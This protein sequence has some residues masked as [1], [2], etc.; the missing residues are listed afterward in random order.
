MRKIGSICLHIIYAIVIFLLSNCISL[1]KIWSMGG[2][3]CI[4]TLLF[5]L[6]NIIPSFF[7]LSLKTTRLQIL[8]GG[9]QLL[10]LFLFSTV[11]SILYSLVGWCGKLS[12]IGIPLDS[13]I[14]KPLLW[15]FN[16]LFI[17]LIEL[18]VFWNGMIRIFL[19]S[20]QLGIRWRV[21]GAI[22]GFIPVAQLIVLGIMISVAENEVKVENNK[23]LLN[24][25]RKENRICNTKYPLLLV[26][27][28]FFRDSKYMNY[29]GRI[30]K[31]LEQN[32]ASIFYGNHHSAASVEACGQE[33]YERIMEIVKETGC[34][35]F[36]IIAHSKGGLDCRYAISACGADKYVA[37]LTTI[38]TPHRGCE[39][40]DYLLSKIGKKQQEAIAKAYNTTLRKFG[41]TNPDFLTAVRDL[42]AT[43]CAEFNQNVL[44]KETVYYQSI[45]SKIN[46]ASSGRFPLNFS[47][48]LVH[49]FDGKNDGLV[50]EKSFPWGS[51]YQFLSTKGTRGIS[52]GDMIDLNRENFPGF[53]V[54]EFYVQLVS[55][56][57]RQGF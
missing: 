51:K 9:C 11:L 12:V 19:T 30:P 44:D 31:E 48:Q 40:A 32:G 6:L 10:R 23:I 53:D 56:L 37:S 42:T 55:E 7:Q 15:I 52:H 46:K 35:K 38:N 5:I 50:G 34:D 18:I 49:Y 27:G 20:V 14:E 45:G 8:S 13:L 17:F 16:T 43:S 47:Y 54:R 28:V 36:N 21:L 24:E 3:L 33:L 57:K 1:G 2:I 26:H 41:D 29:W 22:C 4:C 39:F 25:A